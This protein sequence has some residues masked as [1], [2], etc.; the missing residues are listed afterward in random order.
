MEMIYNQLIFFSLFQSL[1]LLGV[2]LFF[3]SYRNRLNVFLTILITAL[4]IGLIGKVLH[5]TWDIER[6]IR[7]LLMSEVATSI[8][9][10]TAYLYT[11]SYLE[12]RTATGKDF[13]HYVPSIIYCLTLFIYF[14][15]PSIET[16]KERSASGEITRVVFIVHA[17]ILAINITY[18]A[19]AFKCLLR[20]KKSYEDE[21]SYSVSLRYFIN[22]LTS[23][24]VLFGV[25][26]CV[27]LYSVFITKTF[28]GEIRLYI[29]LL[30]SM[31][32][33][34]FSIYS[35]TNP[36]VLFKLPE[37]A[38]KK[39][40]HSKYST[41]DLE[42]LQQRLELIMQEKKPYLNNKLLKSELAQMLGVSSPDM[43]RLLNERIGMNFFE[44][45][46]YHRIQE[47]VHLMKSE[48]GTTMTFFG[49]AQ[50]AGFNSKTTFNKSF[51]K[52]IGVTPSQY[53]KDKGST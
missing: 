41:Q 26:L 22:F 6:A 18:V 42:Q 33:L 16:I 38:E 9:G 28:G 19:L 48:K 3:K 4:T 25:W 24:A 30:M 2:F 44:Y 5:M 21:I 29:W 36:S 7:L 32:I 45:V 46:N 53:F 14:I 39:Y 35:L 15:L 27:Y 10:V 34:M 12:K 49:L 47:F 1:L 23:L 43:A 13:L 52:L 51:K 11:R 31:V 17:Y 37:L 8:F 20:F 50:E 40:A